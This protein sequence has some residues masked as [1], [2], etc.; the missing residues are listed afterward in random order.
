MQKLSVYLDVILLRIRF[1]SKFSHGATVDGN[2]SGR[3]QF[4][5]LAPGSDSRRSD[6]LL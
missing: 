4:L 3:D 2:P 6:D 1:G 5:G